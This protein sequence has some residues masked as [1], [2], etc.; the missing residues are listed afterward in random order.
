MYIFFL[1]FTL[2]QKQHIFTVLQNHKTYVTILPKLFRLCY[3]GYVSVARSSYLVCLSPLLGNVGLYV[4]THITPFCCACNMIFLVRVI[5]AF[6]A[7]KTNK[8][9]IQSAVI[10]KMHSGHDFGKV[11]TIYI[12]F[13]IKWAKKLLCYC[14]IFFFEESHTNEA[15]LTLMMVMTYQH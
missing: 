11:L 15:V 2:P 4:M 9:V 5:L 1:F 7:K 14:Y 13:P 12:D 3:V 6:M 8:V 10:K